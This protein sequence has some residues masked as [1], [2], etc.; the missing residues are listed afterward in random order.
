MSQLC[1]IPLIVMVTFPWALSTGCAALM[2]SKPVAERYVACPH[3]AIWKGALEVLERY[4]V[5]KKDQEAG[6]IETD[7]HEQPVPNRGYGLFGREGL[8]DKERSRLTMTLKPIRNNV[9][10]VR[11]S[12]R[13][14]HWGFRGG[15][16]IYAWAPVEPN[17]DGLEHIMKQFTT[18]LKKQGCF[19]E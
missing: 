12:E 17:L 9:V 11:L 4:P 15:G 19:V 1:P 10:I 5:S 14:Q 3:D 18:K 16:R 2:P 6:V 7:W 13:R 8:G